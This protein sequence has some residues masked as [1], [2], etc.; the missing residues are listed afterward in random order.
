MRIGKRQGLTHE[1]AKVAGGQILFA[2]LDAFHAVFER[3]RDAVEQG[4]GAARSSAVGDVIAQ[5]VILIAQDHAG[6]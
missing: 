4:T 6:S 3:A 2:N 5:Q 1:F